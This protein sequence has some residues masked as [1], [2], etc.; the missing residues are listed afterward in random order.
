MS[1]S[2]PHPFRWSNELNLGHVIQSVILAGAIAAWY[3]GLDTRIQVV[4]QKTDAMIER[5]DRDDATIQRQLDLLLVEIRTLRQ[6]L[7]E[8]ERQRP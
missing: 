8:I 7:R 2:N 3:F 1:Q 6:E 5:M 4:E